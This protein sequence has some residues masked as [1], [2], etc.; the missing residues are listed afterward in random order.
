MLVI[1]RIYTWERRLGFAF[2]TGY[3]WSYPDVVAITI[4]SAAI[5]TIPL[6]IFVGLYA[7]GNY[8]EL[9][10][11]YIEPQVMVRLPSFQIILIKN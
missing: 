10:V 7:S 8:A 5:V 4:E 1:Y 11:F 9:V 3:R 2:G 6:I